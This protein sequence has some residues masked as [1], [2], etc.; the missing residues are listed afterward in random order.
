MRCWVYQKQWKINAR[1][2]AQKAGLLR[3]T[4]KAS[5]LAAAAQ[6]PATIEDVKEGTLASGYVANVTADA[7]FVRFLGT[8]TGRAGAPR[9]SHVAVQKKQLLPSIAVTMGHSKKAQAA[10][11][12]L[13]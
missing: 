9:G 13:N 3:V 11:I 10:M 5:L 8:L 6:L 4:R 12:A 1:I 7:V 2:P